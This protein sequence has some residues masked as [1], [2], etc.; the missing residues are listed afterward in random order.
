MLILP[1]SNALS[2]FRSAH[3]LTQLQVIAPAITAVSARYQHFV[4]TSS[5]LEAD[6]LGRLRELLTYGDSFLADSKGESESAALLV[7]P[8]FG[9]ISPWSSK[10]SDIAFQCGLIP[11]ERIERGVTYYLRLKS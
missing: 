3:L 5:E 10:A 4:D 1:G 8:R 2:A 6:D 11:V 9:T 7:L